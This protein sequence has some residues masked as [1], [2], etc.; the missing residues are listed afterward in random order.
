VFGQRVGGDPGE[1]DHASARSALG[2]AEVEVAA[3]IDDRLGDGDGPG[4]H[5]DP[6]GLQSEQLSSTKPETAWLLRAPANAARLFESLAQAHAGERSV[7][8]LDQ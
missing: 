7:H 2:R 1:R 6:L 5:V 8:E 3:D 4:E